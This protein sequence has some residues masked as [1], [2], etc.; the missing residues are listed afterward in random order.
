MSL[1]DRIEGLKEPKI[2]T[3]RTSGEI[4]GTERD[5]HGGI[6]DLTCLV[7]GSH[8]TPLEYEYSLTSPVGS[9]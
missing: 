2:G 6:Y 5:G 9:I 1:K 7:R 3:A 4:I 8:L